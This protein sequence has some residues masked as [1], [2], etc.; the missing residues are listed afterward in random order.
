MPGIDKPAAENIWVLAGD[1]KLPELEHCIRAGGENGN[2]MD[3]DVQDDSGYTPLHA[4]CSYGHHSTVRIL[5]DKYSANVNI[6]DTDGDT[7]LHLVEDL[8]M[9]AL[10]IAHGA[11]PHLRNLCGLLVFELISPSKSLLL[12][13]DTKSSGISR[14]PLLTSIHTRVRRVSSL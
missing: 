14:V 5:L 8:E 1:G 9:A 6:T 12:N 4:A 10:L 11:D 13:A 7:P 2:P 3:V